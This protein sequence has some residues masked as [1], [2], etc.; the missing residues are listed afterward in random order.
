MPEEKSTTACSAR[1]MANGGGITISEPVILIGQHAPK[2]EI[3]LD[4]I[5]DR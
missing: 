5:T 1:K 2:S 3:L 4:D